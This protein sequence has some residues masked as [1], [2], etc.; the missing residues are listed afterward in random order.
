MASYRAGFGSSRRGMKAVWIGSTSR[1]AWR[2][3]AL[4]ASS[5][6]TSGLQG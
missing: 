1:A 2:S 6:R 5:R 4:R 3:I